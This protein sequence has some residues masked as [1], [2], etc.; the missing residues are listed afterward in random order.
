VRRSETVPEEGLGVELLLIAGVVAAL[1]IGAAKSFPQMDDAYLLLLIKERGVG[2]IREAHPDRPLVGAL[3]QR[4]ASGTGASFWRTGLL[5]HLAL[6]FGVGAVTGQ[7][8]RRLFPEFARFAAAASVLAVAPVVVRTQLSTVTLSL[9]DLLSMLPVWVA[10]LCAWSFAVSGRRSSLAAAVLL[11][12]GGSVLSEYGAVA[13]VCAAVLIA[14]AAPGD[15]RRARGIGLGLLAA[16]VAGYAVYA[17]VGN[18][19]GRPL[20]EPGRQLSRPSL[21]PRMVF[22]VVTRFWDTVV[23]DLFRAAS[24]VDLE[25]QTKS[26]LL[27]VGAGVVLGFLLWR[28]TR[29]S[30]E[31]ASES[32]P[33]RMRSAAALA[34]ALAAGLLP[35]AFMRPVFRSDFASRFEIPVLPVA[36][37]LTVAFLLWVARDRAR[38]L[39]AGFVGL[40]VGA[41]V[42]HAAADAVRQRRTMAAAGAALEPIARSRSGLT[43]AVVAGDENLCYT[44]QVCTGM[45]T[46]DW[47]AALGRKIWVETAAEAARTLGPRTGC[48][49]AEPVGLAERGFSRG[50]TD[51]PP[52]WVE[53]HDSRAFLQPYCIGPI[54]EEAHAAR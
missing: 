7:L 51:G 5:A 47:D 15:A 37:N 20:V 2:A 54:A 12:A 9:L 27:A 46:R 42:V 49:P 40:V 26:S 45:V 8:W 18:F 32:L 22:N 14:I 50:P 30:S 39:V 3:W 53:V 52:V 24:A 13:G 41:S 38:P 21:L 44:A 17:R 19:A 10:A 43:L 35:I 29:R 1:T 16:G 31:V 33:L 4:L 23:G 36:S 25:W 34:A 6:W 11:A 28:L 48:R